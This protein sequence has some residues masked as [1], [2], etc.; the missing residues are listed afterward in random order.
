M[1]SSSTAQRSLRKTSIGDV[2]GIWPGMGAIPFWLDLIL[3]LSVVLLVLVMCVTGVG[4]VFI[5]SP[6]D[7]RAPEPGCRAS[8]DN[9]ELH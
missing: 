4:P 6:Q 5:A 9:H 2:V 3:G 7:K 1:C 8:S